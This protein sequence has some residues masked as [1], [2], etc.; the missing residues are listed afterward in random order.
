MTMMAVIPVHRLSTPPSAPTNEKAENFGTSTYSLYSE[1]SNNFNLVQECIPV[2]FR[3]R[4]ARLLTLS[5]GIWGGGT[6]VPLP[7]PCTTPCHTHPLPHMPPC[8]KHP[9]CH[10][11]PLPHIH[12]PLPAMHAPHC[13]QTDTCKNITFAFAGGKHVSRAGVAQ[14]VKAHS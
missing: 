10:T 14:T 7:L 1:T 12:I 4:T 3:M 11:C 5:R 8:H 2:G 6:C 9:L 13:G